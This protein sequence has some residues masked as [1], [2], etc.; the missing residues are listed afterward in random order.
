MPQTIDYKVNV[1]LNEAMSTLQMVDMQMSQLGGGGGGGYQPA[2]YYPTNVEQ[3]FGDLSFSAGQFVQR[4]QAP[5]G[6]I[7]T[8]TPGGLSSMP[9]INLATAGTAVWAPGGLS[10][11]HGVARY[12]FERYA[13]EQFSIQ[14][15]RALAGGAWGAAKATMAV[16]GGMA[17][18]KIGAGI[19]TMLGGPGIGTM[20]GTMVGF[21]G[22][23][24]ALGPV[25]GMLQDR[26]LLEDVVRS[27]SKLG[28]DK[29]RRVAGDITRMHLSDPMISGS[30]ATMIAGMGAQFGLMGDASSS[31]GDY[32]KNFRKLTKD[33]KEVATALGTSLQEGMAAMAQ[34]KGVGFGVGQIGGVVSQLSGMAGGDPGKIRGL[35]GTGMMGASAFH[36]TG[37]ARTGGFWQAIGTAGSVGAAK[38]TGDVSGEMWTQAGGTGGVTRLMLGSN[39]QFQESGMGVAMQAGLWQGGTKMG[40]YGGGSAMD[41]MAAGVGGMGSGDWLSF[42]RNRA[43]AVGG[44]SQRD[45][46]MMHAKS[47]VEIGGMWAE[48]MGGN[49]EDALFAMAQQQGMNTPQA[50]AWA[51]TIQKQASGKFG[52]GGGP[53]SQMKARLVEAAAKR[54]AENGV[55]ALVGG[56]RNSIGRKYNTLFVEPISAIQGGINEQ[57]SDWVERKGP[58]VGDVETVLASVDGNLKAQLV[59][60]DGMDISGYSWAEKWAERQ[61]RAGVGFTT[62]ERTGWIKVDEKKYYYSGDAADAV[63]EVGATVDRAWGTGFEQIQNGRGA[64]FDE[65]T[66]MGSEW[67]RGAGARA[68]VRSAWA[69]GGAI[70]ALTAIGTNMQDSASLAAGV[71]FLQDFHGK[72]VSKDDIILAQ[73]QELAVIA[74]TGERASRKEL[75]GLVGLG[76]RSKW[77][78][79]TGGAMDTAGPDGIEGTADDPTWAKLNRYSKTGGLGKGAMA[80]G[81]AWGAGWLGAAAVAGAEATTALFSSDDENRNLY[82]KYAVDVIKYL[83]D[84]ADVTTGERARGLAA[85][86]SSGVDRRSKWDDKKGAYVTTYTEEQIQASAFS[87]SRADAELE[88][89]KRV[90]SAPDFDP[91]LSSLHRKTDEATAEMLDTVTHHIET[92]GGPGPE[93]GAGK[94]KGKTIVPIA[95]GI[96]ATDRD[97]YNAV[98]SLYRSVKALEGTIVKVPG[99]G[100]PTGKPPGTK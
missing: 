81:I 28:A 91:I 86:D 75:R 59:K 95:M 23:E 34:L 7:R 78:R 1:D 79:M 55:D 64:A 85:L 43:E 13:S 71:S 93:G 80:R 36:G 58:A 50:Q 30:D 3:A 89:A 12:D 92:K 74:K 100:A 38:G 72:E 83:D 24:A 99:T 19:G 11:P 18:A 37:M 63:A 67:G 21:V 56:F 61:D 5:L 87:V 46:I 33:A 73:N 20:V 48:S 8:H 77:E 96:D 68:Q 53:R 14:G 6:N 40:A 22:A 70:G 10:V 60:M 88:L 15:S 49:L 84:V 45:R 26:A 94:K 66:R 4:F 47:Q 25:T 69:E 41:L 29:S 62:R 52:G 27:S 90:K 9:N 35:I 76:D 65:Y 54:N 2:P 97:L 44:M 42:N 98:S 32:L 31:S 16:G 17:G 57:I 82:D 51:S 39:M